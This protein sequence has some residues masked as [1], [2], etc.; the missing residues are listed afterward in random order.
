MTHTPNYNLSQWSPE[1]RILR[2]DFN[3]DNDRIDAALASHAGTLATR[4]NCSISVF[5]YTGTGKCGEA[6]PT[7]ITFPRMP[8][9]FIV[10]GSDGIMVG[11]GGQTKAS[12]CVY[13]NR[14]MVSQLG[15]V[16]W[17]G[18]TCSFYNNM[19]ASIQ[20]NC[21]DIHTVIAFYAES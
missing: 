4:G 3:A 21:S 14:A 2:D 13:G 11:R 16:T 6:N 20:L 1:D 17:S 19:Q 7:R 9:V 8:A 18:T 5:T 12:F 10:A 15:D